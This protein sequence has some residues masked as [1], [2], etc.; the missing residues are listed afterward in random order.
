MIGDE[1]ISN[2]SRIVVE[3]AGR[4]CPALREPL[5]EWR[6]TTIGW[7]PATPHRFGP[8]SREIGIEV[9]RVSGKDFIYTLPGQNNFDAVCSGRMREHI[10]GEISS[11]EFTFRHP[12]H[13]ADQFRDARA[14]RYV[15]ECAWNSPIFRQ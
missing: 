2:K 13:R 4:L 15:D 6:K 7:N 10:A 5:P 9:R 14:R 8:A 11:I 1:R 3:S 12:R